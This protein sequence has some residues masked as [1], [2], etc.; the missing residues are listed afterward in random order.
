MLVFVLLFR[1]FFLLLFGDCCRCFLLSSRESK[2]ALLFGDPVIGYG[3]YQVVVFLHRGNEKCCPGK[4]VVMMLARNKYNAGRGWPIHSRSR[5]FPHHVH[6]HHRSASIRVFSTMDHNEESKT[7]TPFRSALISGGIAGTAVDVALFPI[8]TIKT[9]LQSP[10]GFWKAGGF[11]GIYNGLTAVTAGSAPGAALFFST[12]E[13]MKCFLNT[14]DYL[15]P[16]IQHMMASSVGEVAACLVRVPTE[17]VK[18]R[19]QTNDTAQLIPT[20]RELLREG[21]MY[22]GFGITLF[23]EIPF[24]CIQFP[25]YEYLK[26]Q[27]L[28]LDANH[29]AYAALCGSFAGAV[30]A[31]A[32]T[33]L[34]VLKTRFMLGVDQHGIRYTGIFDVYRKSSNLDLWKGIQPRVFWISLGGYIFFGAYETSRKLLEPVLG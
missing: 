4:A 28:F 16:A 27:S 8:D 22:R 26:A 7:S 12:Y 6:D 18:S 29:P 10:S 34:D 32:T 33:P 15:H 1:F 3:W 13:T 2:R 21:S 5:R 11:R 19:M 9:R 20:V 31:A 25:L 23:R 30:A 17:V 24:C 14:T